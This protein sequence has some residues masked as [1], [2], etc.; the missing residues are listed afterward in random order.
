M[1]LLLPICLEVLLRPVSAQS[2]VSEALSAA[3]I[4]PGCS[5]QLFSDLE[6]GDAH[7]YTDQ[8]NVDNPKILWGTPDGDLVKRGTCLWGFIEAGSIEAFEEARSGERKEVM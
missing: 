6:E 5:V 4:P 8:N 7:F 1:L 2:C 3:K